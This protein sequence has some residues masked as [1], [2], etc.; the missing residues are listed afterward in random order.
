MIVARKPLSSKVVPAPNTNLTRVKS[1]CIL[2]VTIQ[3]N[4]RM[5]EHIRNLVISAGQQ[6]YAPKTLKVHGLPHPALSNVCR[7]TLISRLTYASPA[8]WGFLNCDEVGQL[9]A[10]VS[11]AQRWGIYSKQ[12]DSLAYITLKADEKLF[13][14]ILNNSDHVLHSLLP[15]IKRHNH[16]L[17]QRP[18]NR[19]L[20]TLTVSYTKNNFIPRMLYTDIY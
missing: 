6:L 13:A 15:P 10:I 14:S 9:E 7:S 18:H 12:A 5:A 11:K 8:W 17:R 19:N 16:N 2:G 20:P 4:L 3:D 1:M